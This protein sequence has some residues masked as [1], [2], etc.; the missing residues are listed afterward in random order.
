MKWKK[1]SVHDGEDMPKRGKVKC[2]SF[3]TLVIC[4]VSLESH[5]H[6]KHPRIQNYMV[7]YFYPGLLHFP[8]SMFS[9]LYIQIIFRQLY[10]NKEKRDTFT[11]QRCRAL[12]HPSINGTCSEG[13]GS[14]V[15]G[16]TH[17]SMLTY[18]CGFLQNRVPSFT[19]WILQQNS[20]KFYFNSSRYM[21]NH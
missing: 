15:K 18:C 12:F 6:Q 4:F 14:K 16:I 10:I 9:S 5:L 17:I 1:K 11:L 2:I 7:L 3:H 19:C 13:E 8:L 20:F 21:E